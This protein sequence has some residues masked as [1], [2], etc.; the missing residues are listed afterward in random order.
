MKLPVPGPRIANLPLN[1]STRLGTGPG[2]G[3]GAGAGGIR[4]LGT[5]RGGELV[6]TA[7]VERYRFLRR[8]G[9]PH[10]HVRL[11]RSCGR[12]H[13]RSR[14]GNVRCLAVGVGG[15][16]GILRAWGR[17]EFQCAV[18]SGWGRRWGRER[19]CRAG[20]RG[21]G[22]GEGETEGEDWGDGEEECGDGVAETGGGVFEEGRGTD[23]GGGG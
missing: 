4:A 20:E 10:L 1:N 16:A 2:T 13:A 12:G 9:P 23:G 8:S 21:K 19:V 11:E 3:A 18:F 7:G 22:K 15:G 14:S 17:G 5:R 6:F